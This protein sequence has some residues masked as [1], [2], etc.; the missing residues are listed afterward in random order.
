MI[1]KRKLQNQK[2]NVIFSMP[3][4]E[5]MADPLYVVG[6]FNNWDETATPM[7]KTD[8]AWSV[9][10]TLDAERDYQYRYRDNNGEWYNDLEADAYVRNSFGSDNSVVSLTNG[11]KAPRK[12][13]PM[14]KKTL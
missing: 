4:L 2:Y 8:G 5:G 1:K 12:K 13:P 14:R 7:Q 10:L 9:K 6:D 3:A 11:E